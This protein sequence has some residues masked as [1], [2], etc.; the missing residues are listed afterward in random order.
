MKYTGDLGC[1]YR[2][3]PHDLHI[4]HQNDRVKV[5]VC[6]ICYR[7]FRWNKGYRG[8]VNNVDYLKAHVRQFCQRNGVTKR[9]FHKIYKPESLLIKI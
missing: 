6:Q 1:K 4:I 9:I 3:I 7:K 2:G 8:R 5:E